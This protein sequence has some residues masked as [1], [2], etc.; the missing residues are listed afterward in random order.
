MEP[1]TFIAGSLAVVFALLALLQWRRAE[2]LE[3]RVQELEGK[4][5]SEPAPAREE[6]P[7]PAKASE[8]PAAAA[9][10]AEDD[11]EDED[12][13]EEDDDEE[14]EEERA[15]AAPKE[16]PTEPA[17][18]PPPAAEPEPPVE[19]EPVAE[20]A[21]PEPEPTPEPPA[22]EPE[23]EPEPDNS[24]RLEALKVVADA[25][26]LAKYLNFDAIVEKPS[27]YRLT[28]PVTAANSAAVRYLEPGMFSCLKHVSVEGSKAVLHIDT[29]KG[30]P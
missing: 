13:D 4:R 5:E 11:D 17:P 30:P 24:L 23:P 8:P 28:V 16:P 9:S 14:E 25:F 26:E 15:E 2:D 29:S 7:K 6:A 3:R 1:F 18:E 20:A 10:K 19:P 21:P 12:E 22:S 27:T